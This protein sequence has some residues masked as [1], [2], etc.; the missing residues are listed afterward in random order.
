M[1]RTHVFLVGYVQIFPQLQPATELIKEIAVLEVEVVHLE[2]YLLSLYRKAFDQQ[3]SSV[4]PPSKEEIFKSPL[5]TP[6]RRCLDFSAPEALPKREA[7]AT[8]DITSKEAKATQS[9]SKSRD[10]QSKE[11]ATVREDERLLDSGVHRCHSNLS[12]RA[13]IKASAPEDSLG[14]AIRSCYS[15]PL[16]MMQVM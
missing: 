12:Q 6:R 5:T 11:R 13:T 8:Q 2:Q 14:R 7:P 3:A 16:S 4:S 15:Q 10:I 1:A 9:E